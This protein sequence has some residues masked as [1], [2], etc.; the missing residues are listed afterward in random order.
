MKK[1]RVF[2][3]VL[4]IVMLLA[5]AGLATWYDGAVQWAA[6]ARIVEKEPAPN[7]D[8]THGKLIGALYEAAK[9]W[10]KDVSAW[11]DVNILSYEDAIFL[12]EG[13]AE[14]FQWACA[15]GLIAPDA[16]NLEY[17]RVLSREEMVDLVYKFAGWLELDRSVGENTNILSYDDAFD[18]SEGKFEGFQWACGAG[19][20]IGTAQHVLQPL[21]TA[22]NAQ[23]L[24][25]L[26]RLEALVK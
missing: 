19:L 14:S 2:A 8:L 1:N 26:M 20:I 23:L 22:T 4:A 7:D 10:E 6:E 17:D 24:T 9:V 11:Q 3:M 12:P 13:T 5:T 18:I 15:A 25:V 16:I 21:N